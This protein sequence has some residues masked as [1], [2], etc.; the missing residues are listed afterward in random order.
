MSIELSFNVDLEELKERAERL[1]STIASA[2]EI[3]EG[4]RNF[5]VESDEGKF[6]LDPTIRDHFVREMDKAIAHNRLKNENA[7]LKRA[8]DADLI[9]SSVRAGLR[10]VGVKPHLL[11]AAFHTFMARHKCAVDAQGRV[12][13]VGKYGAANAVRAAVLFMNEDDASQAFAE[14]DATP[15]GGL[16]DALRKMMN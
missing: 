14:L 5:Y 16:T 9:A 4:L 6:V 1:S 11:D 10:N 3:S 12:V 7:H 2:D 8:N 15:Q 13:V